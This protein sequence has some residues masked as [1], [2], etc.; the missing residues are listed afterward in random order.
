MSLIYFLKKYLLEQ[1]STDTKFFLLEEG[2]FSTKFSVAV[3]FSSL[4]IKEYHVTLG[5]LLPFCSF[6]DQFFISSSQYFTPS[7]SQN[8]HIPSTS[9]RPS[10]FHRRPSCEIGLGH[11]PHHLDGPWRVKIILYQKTTLD[12]DSDSYGCGHLV[13]QYIRGDRLQLIVTS[14]RYNE[15][16]RGPQD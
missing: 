13:V 15:C 1:I 14:R 3:Y 7:S 9:R 2:K 16:K 6:C 8:I 4:D 12:D 10:V 5:E 11:L